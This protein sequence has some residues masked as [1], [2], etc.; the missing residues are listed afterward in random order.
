LRT[1]IARGD[2]DQL[3]LQ[4]FVQKYGPTV[5]AAPP[6]SGFNL[7]AWIA[8][9]VVFLLAMLGAALV[10]RKWKLHTVAM[11][12]AFGAD[13]ESTAILDRVRKETEL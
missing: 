7:V 11:P 10:I 4:D 12:T 8:P 5:L 13:P 6:E 2:S 1:A 9:G 3:I